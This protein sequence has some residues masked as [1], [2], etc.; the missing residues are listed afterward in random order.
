MIIG[1]KEH[2]LAAFTKWIQKYPSP[3]RVAIKINLPFLPMSSSPKTDAD[4]LDDVVSCLLAHGYYVT[5]I[6]G[7]NGHLKD[8]VEAIG[9]GH[10]FTNPNFNLIDTDNET[11]RVLWVSRGG[12]NYPLP[13][14]L[15]SMD[16]RLAIPCAT[17][18]PGFLFSCNIKT[19]VGLLPRIYC[20]NGLDVRFSRPLIHENLTETISDL[21]QIVCEQIPFH[22]FMNG[23]NTVSDA[24][25]ILTLPQYYC[26]TDPIELDLLL[27]NLL[28]TQCPPYLT[29]LITAKEEQNK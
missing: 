3:C 20:Q 1:N 8:Y 25:P 16:I 17:K 10:F 24:S 7:A 5:L 19:F 9:L 11:N 12:R 13:A 2:I 29:K 6:E 4:F 21:Y 27:V 22:L 28:Q 18:R 26:S 23:G 15:K 14:I